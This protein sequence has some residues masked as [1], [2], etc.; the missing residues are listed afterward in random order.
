MKP[1]PDERWDIF[2]SIKS[3]EEYLTAYQYKV[4][5]KSEVNEHVIGVFKLVQRLIELAYYEY[6]F[7]DLACMKAFLG[8]ELALKK[9]FEEISGSEASKPKN[10]KNYIEWFKEGGYFE[11]DSQEFFNNIRQIRNI[12]AHP[13]FHSFG[14]PSVSHHIPIIAS[15]I[16]DLYEDRDLR[17]ERNEKVSELSTFLKEQF[18]SGAVLRKKDGSMDLAFEFDAIFINNKSSD[19][20]Y[21]FAYQPIFDLPENYSPKDSLIIHPFIQLI[22]QSFVLSDNK[23]TAFNS[24]A[25]FEFE[26]SYPEASQLEYLNQWFQKYNAYITLVQHFPIA[27]FRGKSEIFARS[28]FQFHQ[29]PAT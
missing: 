13:V 2:F 18:N 10:L 24:R 29:T 16:N 14:G 8:F 26:V 5:L 21:H 23:L 6:E 22:A 1:T 3:Y 17:R 27:N 4:Y 11:T 20:Q 15:L 9:R 25:E 19:T 28:L 7:W 12:F